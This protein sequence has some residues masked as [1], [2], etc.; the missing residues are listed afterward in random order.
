MSI[1]RLVFT[2]HNL[3]GKRWQVRAD[4]SYHYDAVYEGDLD[5][6]GTS[7]LILAMHAGGNGLS[8]STRLIFLT[9]D[10]NGEPH[11]FE[12][13]GYYETHQQGIVDVETAFSHATS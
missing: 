2:G 3:K 12:A 5:R 6:N 7:D 11:I 13:T 4:A 9:V 8:L 10:R 1:H